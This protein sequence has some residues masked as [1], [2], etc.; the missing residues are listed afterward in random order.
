MANEAFTHCNTSTV[1]GAVC[2][3]RVRQACHSIPKGNS[4]SPTLC[5]IPLGTMHA[6]GCVPGLQQAGRRRLGTGIAR[7]PSTHPP[8]RAP[9]LAPDCSP[10]AGRSLRASWGAACHRCQM[11]ERVTCGWVV[12]REGR[13]GGGRRSKQSTQHT[14]ES[15]EN[16]QRTPGMLAGWGGGGVGG[17]GWLRRSCPC[18]FFDS[19]RQ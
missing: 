3:A 18:L 6:H 10:I 4:P 1:T 5:P 9:R 2:K 19:G 15:N 7:S 12:W 8:P 16:G 11:L 14:H 17:G 13:R